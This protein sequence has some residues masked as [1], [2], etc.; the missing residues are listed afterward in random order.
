MAEDGSVVI[1]VRF[2]TGDVDQGVDEIEAGCRRAGQAASRLRKDAARRWRMVSA[3]KASGTLD[4]LAKSA[5]GA[6][7][8][9][10]G[11]DTARTETAFSGLERS[12]AGAAEGLTSADTALG[13]LG[14][15]LA[16]GY[17]RAA[18]F[19]T[20]VQALT[21]LVAGLGGTIREG[22]E[23]L[24]QCDREASAAL[25]SLKSSLSG[26]QGALITAFAPIA[27]AVAPQLSRLCSMLVTAANY[28]AMFFAILGGR[29]TYKR[30]VIGASGAAAGISAVSQAAGAATASVLGLDGAVRVA[31][32]STDE[33][34]NKSA[35]AISAADDAAR[36]TAGSIEAIGKAAKKTVRNLS[37]LDEMNIW[38]VKEGSSGGGSGGSGGGSG[39]GGGLDIQD[40]GGITFDEVPIDQAFAEKVGW[41]QENFDHILTAAQAVGAAILTWRVARSLGVGLESTLG[42]T[43]AVG[44]A[45]LAVKG[46]MDAWTKGTDLGSLIEMLGGTALAAGGLTA[47]FG[48]TGGAVGAFTGGVGMLLAAMREWIATG[49]IT[50]A[51]LG[52]MEGGILTV[53]GALALL[54]GTWIPLA[55]AA[56]VGLVTAAVAR[57]D[58]LKK[59][60]VERFTA[61]KTWLT[62]C[63]ESIR[64]SVSEKAEQI[65][66]AVREKFEAVRTAITE[67]VTD[68]WRRVQEKF[69]QIRLA[70]TEKV[71]GAWEAVQEKFE[72]I[73]A[74]VADKLTA[75][76]QTAL[77]IFDGVQQGIADKI[78][79]AKTAV[80]NAV[81]KIKSFFNFSWSL[82]KIKLPHFSVTGKFSL[83]PPS[84]PHF[85]VDWY[86]RGGIVDGATLIGAGEAGREAIIPLERHTQWLDAVA[87]RLAARLGR[88]E[89]TVGL[90]ETA[91]RLGQ[92][93]AAIDRLGLSIRNVP[94]PVLASGTVIPPRAAYSEG[95]V[96]GLVDT[97]ERLRQLL[98]SGRDQTRGEAQYT[99]IA[100]MNGRDIF[101]EVIA[102]GKL[103]Q[104]RTGKNPFDLGA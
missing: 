3:E 38:K 43:A 68:A 48:I 9:A 27:S 103:A 59:W 88:L 28:V 35:Q 25:S 82:P 77:D 65:K 23:S 71:S 62:S 63:W 36:N 7:R 46:T 93:A 99:F 95:A 17:R 87:E 8:A 60:T 19:G 24:A 92:L 14:L 69:E 74:A 94:V 72:A 15:A 98:L 89:P 83:N 42:L 86:A 41:L 1:R 20:G 84:I 30:A 73:R 64:R 67:K 91:E 5:S 76:R 96:Q 40:G 37:G 26:V 39:A 22:M 47:A 79:G 81:E 75:T 44:G 18:L 31:S 56:A 80:K 54:T 49:K 13:A 2:E 53:G 90:E 55:V 66:T 100:R 85:S 104:S 29:S 101:R 58:E 45:V 34:G 12:T 61:I 4:S 78:E 51:G 16:G 10:D 52:G 21:A 11:L 97:A 32:V 57:W 102:E 70:V 33:L 50:N 6:A